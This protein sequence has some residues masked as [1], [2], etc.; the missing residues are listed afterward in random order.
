MND[1]ALQ[2]NLHQLLRAMI[3]GLNYQFLQIVD[4][5]QTSLGVTPDRFV[6]VGGGARIY[7]SDGCGAL[8]K[9][10]DFGHVSLITGSTE[11]GQGSE[12]VLAQMVA[13]VLG[14][15]RHPPDDVTEGHPQEQAATQA[16]H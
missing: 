9:V 16:G 10:D 7:R 15:E 4:G 2:V 13:E 8:V 14:V 5:L 11:I 12:T 1:Q 3:E 6:A